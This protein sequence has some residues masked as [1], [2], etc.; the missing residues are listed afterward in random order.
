[1]ESGQRGA[2]DDS[3]SGQPVGFDNSTGHLAAPTRHRHQIRPPLRYRHAQVVPRRA[4]FLM[5][6]VLRLPSVND[7]WFATSAGERPLVRDF[8]R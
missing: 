1:M 5:K 7:I 8:C 6:S 2:A 4:K 3:L